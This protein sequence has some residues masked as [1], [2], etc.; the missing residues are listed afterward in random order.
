M[1]KVIIVAVLFLGLTLPAAAQKDWTSGYSGITHKGYYA[2][3]LYAVKSQTKKNNAKRFLKT[4]FLG[5]GTAHKFVPVG[6]YEAQ[7]A[8]RTEVERVQTERQRTFVN[9]ATAHQHKDAILKNHSYVESVLQNN[10]IFEDYKIYARN[11]DTFSPINMSLGQVTFLRLFF[12]AP[13]Q[14]TKRPAELTPLKARLLENGIIHYTFKT[15]LHLI[16]NPKY[17]TIDVCIGSKN[18]K[19][20]EELDSPVAEDLLAN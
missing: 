18:L 2:Y 5:L 17:K 12:S 10:D 3:W 7:D 8:V 1:K 11:A 15:N 19:D 13:T 14:Q 16:I 20:F 9:Q 6:A 4:A